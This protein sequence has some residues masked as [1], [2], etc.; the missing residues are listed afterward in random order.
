M[1]QVLWIDQFRGAICSG[2][3]GPG[4]CA[5]VARYMQNQ[6]LGGQV[7]TPQSPSSIDTPP[8]MAPLETALVSN[9][10]DGAARCAEMV[11]QTQN[12]NTETFLTCTRGAI[13]LN[14]D[15][16]T[17][18]SCVEQSGGDRNQLA[19]CAGRNL[20]GSRLSQDQMKAIGCITQS[21]GQAN[22]FASCVA[23]GFV[24]NQL[25]RDQ[26]VVFNCAM[27]SGG[28]AQQF[29]TCT[30]QQFF[31][32]KLTPEAQVALGCA[33]QSGGSVQ[34]FGGCAANQFLNLNLNPE[35]Q[36]ALQCVVQSGGQPYVAAGCT[37]SQLTTR[38]LQ[39]CFTNG[40]GGSDGCFG[41]NN[42]LVGRNGFVVRNIAA[43]AGGPN[44]VIRDPGQ[45]LGGNNSVF[46]NPRQLLGGPNSV[47]N[48]ALRNVPSP[49]PIQLGKIGKHR[50]CIPWC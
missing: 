5:D 8:N 45:L 48:Q 29:G 49:P 15:N 6:G 24:T 16:A 25:S 18:L 21:G 1:L 40:I 36:I 4:P 13:V 7:Q 37:A 28:N 43:L 44:S 35:Q 27:Y 39:K 32:N 34:A 2:P 11:M 46:N 33:I 26:Q 10:A 50:V 47:V 9:S 20:I 19:L 22:V 14:Q 17:L 38:E 41:N 3:L 30:A 12:L 31:G 23:G 42:D